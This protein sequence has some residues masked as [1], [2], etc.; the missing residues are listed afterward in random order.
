MTRRKVQLAWIMNASSRKASFKKRRECLM[1]KVMEISTLTGE[2]ACGIVLS[3]EEGDPPVFWPPSINEVLDRFFSLAEADQCKKMTTLDSYMQEKIS[4]MEEQ[5]GKERRKARDE[6]INFV[7]HSIYSHGKKI[8]S[9]TI[10]E[11][12]ELF[13]YMEELKKKCELRILHLNQEN[14]PDSLMMPPPPMMLSSIFTYK[15]QPLPELNDASYA[16]MKN[17]ENHML[18]I[19]HFVKPNAG[20]KFND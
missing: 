20:Y 2:D 8:D 16:E 7:M 9:L 14:S 15:G 5:L 17:M 13:W 1:R 10:G 4:K 6:E 19:H 3:P 12:H 11:T 18:G